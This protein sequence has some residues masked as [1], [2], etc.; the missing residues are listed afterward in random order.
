MKNE[1]VE[2]NTN[3]MIARLNNWCRFQKLEIREN[4]RKTFLVM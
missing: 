2:N 4:K 3:V 1:L